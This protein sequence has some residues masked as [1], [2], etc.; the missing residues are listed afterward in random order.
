MNDTEILRLAEEYLETGPKVEYDPWPRY[1][2]AVLG[3]LDTLTDLNYFE[4]RERLGDKDPG[5]M[6]LEDI[7]TMYTFIRRGERFC[8][9]HIAGYIEDGTLLLLVRR[10]LE[11]LTGSQENTAGQANGEQ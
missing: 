3:A 2:G 5:S 1:N 9:G 7:A 4:N 6:S 11:L 8:D 10:H